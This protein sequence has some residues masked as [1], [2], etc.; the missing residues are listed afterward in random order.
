MVSI[1]RPG[2]THRRSTQH[3]FDEGIG[4][5]PSPRGNLFMMGSS[6]NKLS[7]IAGEENET[8]SC[9]N[10]S[11]SSLHVN[12]IT[13]LTEWI[14]LNVCGTGFFYV[15]LFALLIHSSIRI[16]SR[17]QPWIAERVGETGPTMG[18]ETLGVQGFQFLL[19]LK[20]PLGT[21][22]SFVMSLTKNRLL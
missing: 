9:N 8:T 10:S 1:H 12:S 5:S 3:S 6:M 16:D 11:T 22:W 21:Q 19:T 4:G 7:S 18:M 17:L 2:I 15:L 13:N 14:G 20:L